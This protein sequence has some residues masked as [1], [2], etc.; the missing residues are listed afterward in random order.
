MEEGENKRVNNEDNHPR[1][2]WMLRQSTKKGKKRVEEKEKEQKTKE[3]E[4]KK[5]ER[6]QRKKERETQK[7]RAQ[8]DEK[9]EPLIQAADKAFV[10]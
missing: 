9:V 10:D 6:E 1:E 4:H 3:R 7:P 2:D 8:K 5:K